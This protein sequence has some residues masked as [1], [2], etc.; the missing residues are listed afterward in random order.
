MKEQTPQSMVE[1][2]EVEQNVVHDNREGWTTDS[3]NGEVAVDDG[4]TTTNQPI[5]QSDQ[6]VWSG[7]LNVFEMSEVSTSP[8]QFQENKKTQPRTQ[9]GAEKTGGETGSDFDNLTDS[10]WF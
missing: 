3:T 4:V 2:A 8:T 7:E 9:T 10:D 1:I 6:P 5:W